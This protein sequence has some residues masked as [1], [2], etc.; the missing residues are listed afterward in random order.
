MKKY[1]WLALSF[2]LTLPA[3]CGEK[4]GRKAAAPVVVVQ[5]V[6][7]EPVTMTSR[8][9]TFEVAGTV[10]ARNSAAVLARIAGSVSNIKVREG[11]RVRKGEVIAQLEAQESQA[12]AA[13]ATAA[14]EDAHQ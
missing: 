7:L 3:A 8:P 11:D 5:G 12:G 6:S 13:A 14:M 4:P 10:Q 9:E 1:I 2:M